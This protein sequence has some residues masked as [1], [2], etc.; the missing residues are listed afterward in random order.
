M[1]KKKTPQERFWA[2]VD[3][4]GPLMPGMKTKCWQWTASKTKVQHKNGRIT[5]GG[6]GVFKVVMADN[7]KLAHRVSY[8]WA[9]GPIPAGLQIDHLCNNRACVRPSHLRA[10]TAKENTARRKPYVNG[11]ARRTH[12]P[13]GHE[14]TPDNQRFNGSGYVCTVCYTPG[15]RLRPEFRT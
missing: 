2:K 10:V 6:Y 5:T 8:E 4:D 7:N 12:C 3:K 9:N 11:M 14:R 1:A 13:R 15:G